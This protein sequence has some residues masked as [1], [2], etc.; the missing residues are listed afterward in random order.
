M[1]RFVSPEEIE[2]QLYERSADPCSN[3]VQ[4]AIYALRQ[5]I[6]RPG[7]PS[8]IETRRGLGYVLRGAPA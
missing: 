4:A 5:Q 2:E 6:D 8:L 3:V 1:D 7:E